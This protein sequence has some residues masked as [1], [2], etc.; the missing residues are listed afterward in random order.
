[1]ET[2]AVGF[3]PSQEMKIVSTI[4]KSVFISIMLMAGMD[5]CRSVVPTGP[6]P[7][8]VGLEK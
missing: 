6:S 1:M 8:S 4:K 2:A 7:R 5:I 3:S